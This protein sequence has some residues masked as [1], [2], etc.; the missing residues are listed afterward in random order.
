MQLLGSAL[1][2]HLPQQSGVLHNQK[3]TFQVALLL[4]FFLTKARNT[5]NCIL[6]LIPIAMATSALPKFS[7][8]GGNFYISSTLFSACQ[9]GD[10]QVDL[11]TQGFRVSPVR[12]CV[13]RKYY[14]YFG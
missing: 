7:E 6:E 14:G 13:L 12:R 2:T 1:H 4:F 9:Q 3:L 11:C 5:G 8:H 10:L